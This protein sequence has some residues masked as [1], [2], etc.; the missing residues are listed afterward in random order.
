MVRYQD[1]PGA[2]KH[3]RLEPGK[4][5]TAIEHAELL[6]GFSG[7]K[8]IVLHLRGKTG[9]HPHL[10]V[11]WESDIS[12]G[13]TNQTVKNHL[14]AYNAAFGSYSGQQMWS[15]RNHNSYETWCNYVL[16][17]GSH[18]VLLGN[19]EL[20]AQ[21]VE[22][23]LLITAEP[24]SPETPVR[25]IKKPTA[26]ERLMRFCENELHWVRGNHFHLGH[27][28]AYWQREA[29]SAVVTHTN[30]RLNNAQLQ[31]QVRNVM[32][33]FGDDDVK[34]YFKMHVGESVN[35]F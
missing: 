22:A 13:V 5:E 33:V 23:K 8:A 28:T 2:E 35:F 18:Q 4:R 29:R 15:M 24:L 30:N 34:D 19:P 11:W 16:K 14:K 9:E 1:P 20:L 17:N 32:Y 31:A 12:G 21:S 7:V 3:L 25:I 26:E 27:G 6:K 10:H